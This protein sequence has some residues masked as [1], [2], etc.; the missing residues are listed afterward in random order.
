MDPLRHRPV[1][2]DEVV[3][4]LGPALEGGG[5]VVDG[6]F[7]RG[8]HAYRLLEA[9]EHVRLVGIDRDPDAISEG[10]TYLAPF[11]DRIDLARDDFQGL[12]TVLERLGIPSLRGVLLDLGVSSPQLDDPHR[13]F[14]YRSDGPLDMRMDPSASLS[15]HDVVNG[16]PAPAL[17]GVIRRYGEER[18]ASRIARAIVA[19]RPIH[20]TGALAGIVRDAIPAPA[21]RTG[22]HPARRTFQ[23][24]RI[25]VNNELEALEMALPQVIDALEPGGRVAVIAYHSLE[26]RI[27]KRTFAAEARDCVCPPDLPVCTCGAR[28]RARVLTRRPVRPGRHELSENPRSSSARLR[29]AEKLA[30]ARGGEGGP[31]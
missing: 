7:G 17:T 26:D 10:R 8:G 3:D 11:E 31:A 22:P 20:T 13:G 28:A 5:V 6:T 4:L 24:I 21:R 18:F 29:A 23:A 2:A 16:Y 25:E 9:F 30:A 14:G 15:A 1:L 19:H 27:V 12:P